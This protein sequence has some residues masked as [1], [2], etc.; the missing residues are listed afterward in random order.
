MVEEHV[1]EHVRSGG[2]PSGWLGSRLARLDCSS[3]EG[4]EADTLGGVRGIGPDLELKD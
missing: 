2:I 1:E 3:P 4:V